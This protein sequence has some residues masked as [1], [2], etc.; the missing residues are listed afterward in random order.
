MHNTVS[1]AWLP[2]YI[3]AT[4]P[5]LEIFKTAGSFPNSPRISVVHEDTGNGFEWEVGVGGWEA[6]LEHHLYDTEVQR[7]KL[8][9]DKVRI[10]CRLS[11]AVTNF[12]IENDLYVLHSSCL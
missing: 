5:V 6:V 1:S 4:R 11:I 3:K 7:H 8:R 2:S 10:K 12:V 9:F